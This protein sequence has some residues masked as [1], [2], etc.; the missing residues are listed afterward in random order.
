MHFS[1][2]SWGTDN[3]GKGCI[4]CGPQEQFY[5]CADV[6]IGTMYTFND[7]KSAHHVTSST[8]IYRFI[9]GGWGALNNPASNKTGKALNR[10]YYKQTT[11]V[12]SPKGN[13]TAP[14]FR[15]Q[16]FDKEPVMKDAPSNSTDIQYSFCKVLAVLSFM[17]F[18]C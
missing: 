12:S 13:G 16:D 5:G 8:T 4:G 18:V 15:L 7:V 10:A 11:I 1:G 2:N 17:Y 9:K 6:S 14:G 3:N